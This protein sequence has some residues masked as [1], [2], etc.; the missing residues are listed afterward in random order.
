[1]QKLHDDLYAPIIKKGRKI[2]TKLFVI[3]CCNGRIDL[4]SCQCL[5]IDFLRSP[6]SEPPPSPFPEPLPPSQNDIAYSNT[7]LERTVARREKQPGGRGINRRRDG[8]GGKGTG[9]DG[10]GV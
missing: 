8:V 5:M 3:V 10:G 9:Y 1:M 2:P 7:L 4:I 6:P